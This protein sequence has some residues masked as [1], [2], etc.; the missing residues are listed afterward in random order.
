MESVIEAETVDLQDEAAYEIDDDLI[1][2][3]AYQIHV[4][5]QGG[6]DFDNWLRAEREL[7]EERRSREDD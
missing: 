7:Q 3:R 4:S 6:T 2:E 5:G 1:A